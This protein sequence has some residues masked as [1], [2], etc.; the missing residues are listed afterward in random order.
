MPAPTTEA[1][2]DRLCTNGEI[3]HSVTYPR[4]GHWDVVIAADGDI[5]AWID[6]RLA[7]VTAVSDC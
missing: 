7:G 5:R 3:V 1:L 4:A 2:V 6:D